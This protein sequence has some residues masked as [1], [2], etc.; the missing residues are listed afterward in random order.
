MT[1]A[2]LDKPV[3]RAYHLG[4]GSVV[5]QHKIGLR[6]PMNLILTPR[7]RLHP[8]KA[9]FWEHLASGR[10][11]HCPFA[12]DIKCLSCGALNSERRKGVLASTFPGT[13]PAFYTGAAGH[14]PG[15]DHRRT[16]EK[17]HRRC[18]AQPDRCWVALHALSPTWLLALPTSKPRRAQQIAGIMQRTRQDAFVL[19]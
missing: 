17:Q 19:Q 18:W 9:R 15:P 13:E 2:H 11:N 6:S 16:E 1:P 5:N 4:K 12:L 14:Q 3:H 10:A 8:R 7:K